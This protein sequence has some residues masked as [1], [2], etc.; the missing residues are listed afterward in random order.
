VTYRVDTQGVQGP[1]TVA[2]ELLY[3]PLSYQ[4]VQD[5]LTD[6]TDLTERFGGYYRGTDKT[7]LLVAAIEPAKTE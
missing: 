5:L 7:P 3:E 4:F 2:A 1:F 6:K